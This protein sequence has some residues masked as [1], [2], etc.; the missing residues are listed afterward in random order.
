MLSK[1]LFETLQNSLIL[2]GESEENGGA[3][4]PLC[5]SQFMFHPFI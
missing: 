2:K 3:F 4:S 1:D 5:W